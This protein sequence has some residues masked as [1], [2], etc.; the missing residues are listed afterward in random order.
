[1][2]SRPNILTCFCA[3]TPNLQL[4]LNLDDRRVD[5]PAD[6]YDA[7]IRNGPIADSRLMAWGLEPSRRV[8]IASPA[9]LRENGKPTSVEDLEQH[10]GIFYTNRGVADWRFPTRAGTVL[11]RGRMGFGVNNGDMLRDAAVG[12]LGTRWCRCS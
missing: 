11:V 9:H 5:A 6:G 8:L 4:T 7:V 3:T 10:K 1:M 12:G 2:V